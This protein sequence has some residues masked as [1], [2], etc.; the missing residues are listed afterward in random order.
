MAQTRQSR[1]VTLPNGNR[2]TVTTG[3]NRSGYYKTVTVKRRDGTS[4]SKT[5]RRGGGLLGS[6]WF[7]TGVGYRDDIPAWATGG[8]GATVSLSS[9]QIRQRR[10]IA[11]VV[12]VLIALMALGGYIWNRTHQSAYQDG[13]NWALRWE[14]G[15]L[16]PEPFPGCKLKYMTSNSYVQTDQSIFND[17]VH[18][19]GK[20]HDDYAKWR[21]GCRFTKSYY[22]SQLATG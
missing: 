19:A 17:R 4:D 7:D 6:G 9:A 1:T 14:A 10:S 12:V 22:Q 2:L 3:R 18:G 8:S 20:P 16:G 15:P 21:A 13:R 11:A 5:H